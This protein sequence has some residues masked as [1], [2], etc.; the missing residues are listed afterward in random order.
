MARYGFVFNQ[1]LCIGCNACQMA[2]KDGHNLEMG[3]FFRKVESFELKDKAGKPKFI[4]YSGACNHCSNPACV[5]R[6]STGAMFIQE[7]G[8]VG[9]DDSRCIGCGICTWV[10]PYGAPKLS[11]VTGRAA[12]CDACFERRQ[13]GGKPLCVEACL[14]HCLDFVDLD[15][16]SEEQKA[17]Y[18]NI[19]EVL[20][21][22][23]RT[24]P[25]VLILPKGG[26][27]NE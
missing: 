20:P 21:S 24:C 8:T 16:L 17:Q 4:H 12:K 18:T 27:E 2:C 22:P 14:T 10:C 15:T 3:L 5:E 23:D 6:C 11:S 1:K 9:H 25:S 7:D 13:N 26:L 19:I